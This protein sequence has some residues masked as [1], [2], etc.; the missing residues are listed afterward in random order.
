L[1]Y[2]AF[3]R[4]TE[5]GNWN[6]DARST[7]MMAAERLAV[8]L[9]NTRLLVEAR[10]QALYDEQ[11]SQLGDLIWQTPS[12][13]VIMEQSVR[14]LGRFLGA[15]EAQLYLTPEGV[16]QHGVRLVPSSAGQNEGAARPTGDS[17]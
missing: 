7:I 8:A 6:A 3:T 1:G 15:S 10:R 5:K 11:L 12:P 13:E 17:N 4:A 14:E 9:D 16:E 2:L